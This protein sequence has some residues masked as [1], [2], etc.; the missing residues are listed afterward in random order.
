MK[1]ILS[2]LL[3][4]KGQF[5]IFWCFINIYFIIKLNL[6]EKKYNAMILGSSF[7]LNERTFFKEDLYWI[8]NRVLL[9]SYL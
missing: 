4:L 7:F 9:R 8:C 2:L 3:Q 1:K 5:S 6:I